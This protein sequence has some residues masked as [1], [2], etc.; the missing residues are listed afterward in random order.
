MVL[1][2]SSVVT[3]YLL[4]QNKEKITQQWVLYKNHFLDST[5]QENIKSLKEEQYQGGFITDLFVNILG[6]TKSPTPNYTITTEYK[7]V[8]D[9]KK[10]DGAIIINE[11]VRAVIELKGTNTTD[12]S[13]VENKP[14]VIKTISQNVLMLLLQT[15]KSSGFI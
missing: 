11:N 14:L 3:K 10:A 9:S 4:A 8:K 2:Q 5:I 1:F 13:K 15:L 12:L 7:N 6:Y